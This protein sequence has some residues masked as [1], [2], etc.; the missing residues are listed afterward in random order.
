MPD[1][2]ASLTLM[3]DKFL[4][5]TTASIERLRREIDLIRGLA[6]TDPLEQD[7]ATLDEVS[8]TLNHWRASHD[9]F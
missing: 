7:I 5:D 8:W 2:L 6:V 1:D 3:L 4:E 9:R